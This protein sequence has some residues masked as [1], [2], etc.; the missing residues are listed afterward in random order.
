MAAMIALGEHCS[1]TER[2]ADDATRDVASWLKCE[3][4]QQ[5]LGEV[6]EG[7]ISGVTNFGF[8]VELANLYV[9]GLVHVATLEGDYFQFD[10]QKHRLLGERTGT[11]YGLGDKVMVQ[12][13]SI[14]LEERKVD[15][16]LVS[17]EPRSKAKR[18]LSAKGEGAGKGRDKKRGAKA[19]TGAR[20]KSG[21]KVKRDEVGRVIGKNSA[22]ESAKGEGKRAAEKD[23]KP[24]KKIRD[25][26]VKSK[27]KPKAKSTKSTSA[28][29][30][31]TS[32]KSGANSDSPK[33]RK[34]RLAKK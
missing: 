6:F 32:L 9:E 26:D 15:L 11:R 31:V 24:K 28:P 5:H 29:K 20:G 12:V 27:G 34:R 14:S 7:L 3:Y 19:S 10:P 17:A 18:R 1:M 2:R 16:I 13:A 4:L 25:K 30:Q 33:P 22:K 21:T 23:K 8:F